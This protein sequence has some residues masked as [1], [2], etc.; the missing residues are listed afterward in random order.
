MLDGLQVML[1]M[2]LYCIVRRYVVFR[3]IAFY[4]VVGVQGESGAAERE[5]RYS[6]CETFGAAWREPGAFLV[7]FESVTSQRGLMVLNYMASQRGL[8][9][10][11]H[12]VASQRS[13]RTGN[14]L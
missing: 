12:S 8:T 9:V 1:F 6:M 3:A 10:S 4:C 14:V 5:T 13:G 7:V 2:Q 11:P